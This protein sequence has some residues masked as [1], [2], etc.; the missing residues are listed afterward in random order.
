MVLLSTAYCPNIEWFAIFLSKEKVLIESKENFIKQTYRNRCTILSP[1]G[2]HNL[3]VPVIGGRSK[4]KKLIT[5]I[6]IDYTKNWVD[7]HLKT[8]KT[9]YAS[10]PFFDFFFD[11]IA[12][13]LKQKPE[14]LFDLNI[15]LLKTFLRILQIDKKIELTDRYENPLPN[16]WLDYRYSLSPKNPSKIN[17]PPYPQVFEDKFGFT[18]NL[19]I[20]DLIFNMGNEAI[21]YLKN[22]KI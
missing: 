9:A 7:N 21:L 11:E 16:G 15:A 18:P 2:K 12:Y 6:E 4:N 19:S 20:L 10:A 3:I 8:I 14:K 17:Y 13:T 1:Q 22:I 5:E